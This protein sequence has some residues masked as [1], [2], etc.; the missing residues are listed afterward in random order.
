M[1]KDLGIEELRDLFSKFVTRSVPV[2]DIIV[3]DGTYPRLGISRETVERYKELYIDQ[4]GNG[5]N[6]R[7]FPPI[8]VIPVQRGNCNT[9]QYVLLDGLHRLEARRELGK[10][11][12]SANVYL[13]IAYN[14]DDVE[15]ADF[16]SDLLAVSGLYNMW[17][18]LTLSKDDRVEIVRRLY[19]SG[20]SVQ[21][22]HRYGF[23]PR[24]TITRWLKDMRNERREK[25]K[26]MFLKML[27]EGRHSQQAIAEK[28]GVD[29]TTVSRWIRDFKRGFAPG[30]KEKKHFKVRIKEKRSSGRIPET[31]RDRRYGVLDK[32]TDE[33]L[34]R[35]YNELRRLKWNDTVAIDIRDNLLPLLAHR[36][37]IIADVIQDAGYALENEKL[38]AEIRDLLDQRQ[39]DLKIKREQEALIA[40]LTEDLRKRKEYCNSQCIFTRK[41]AI[42]EFERSVNALVEDFEEHLNALSVQEGPE[43]SLL[44]KLTLNVIDRF[45]SSIEFGYQQDFITDKTMDLFDK[46]YVSFSE[47]SYL[48]DDRRLQNRFR[49]LMDILAEQ[50]NNR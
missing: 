45:L 37:K 43:G 46:V 10:R 12:I 44:K 33:I 17:H 34:E 6:M 29:Q 36:S 23:A 32:E 13:G 19:R 5:S 14:I 25:Q 2:D 27:S 31:G 30:D 24:Q 22:L 50:D 26:E 4:E 47:A 1:F 9:L 49:K 42:K 39:K 41:W 21:K 28:I 38:R 11:T 15:N 20:W 7:R 18:G 16:Q 48:K 8:D 35:I 3:L 40:V